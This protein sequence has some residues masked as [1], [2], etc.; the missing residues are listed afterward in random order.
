MFNISQFLEKFKNLGA[1]TFF[2]RDAVKTSLKEV[3]GIEILYANIVVKNQIARVQVA[4]LVKQMIQIKKV[5]LLEAIQKK[6]ATIK[7]IY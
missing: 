6:G 1:T 2:A 3:L 4:P 7:D 5:V